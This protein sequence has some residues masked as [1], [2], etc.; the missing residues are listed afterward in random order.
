M[1]GAR[2]T[3][4]T[5]EAIA[6]RK[7]REQSK[8]KDYLSLTEDVIARRKKSDWSKDS[9]DLTTR[10]LQINPEFYTV[11]NYRRN[12]MSYGLFVE[13]S[14]ESI[15][16]L[17]SDDLSMTTMALKAHPKVYWIWNHRRWCLENVPDGP[18]DS[19]DWKKANWNRELAVVE[20]MLDADARNFHAWNYRRYVLANMPE[21]RP[22]AAELAYTTRKIEANFSNFSAWHQRSKVYTSLWES[23]QLNREKSI[24]DELELV[25]NAMY[26]DPNDQSAWLYH[27]WLI[28]SGNDREILES[29][30]T[31]IEELLEEQPDSKWCIESLVHYKR[32]LI[33]NHSAEFGAE[34]TKGLLSQCVSFLLQLQTLDPP[35]RNMYQDIVDTLSAT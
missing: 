7:Q 26:T 5:P 23:G 17:L 8:L 10:V 29:E 35:R 9:F 12:I 27:R 28:G 14:P 11:W 15:N 2:R 6:A 22:E 32:L 34:Q 18:G 13:S 3:R 24:R 1:H 31:A 33:K 16:D 30:I 19:H 25:K 4:Q 20:K 21:R